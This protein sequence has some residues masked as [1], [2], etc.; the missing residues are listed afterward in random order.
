MNMMTLRLLL[1]GVAAMVL[2]ANVGVAADGASADV[3]ADTGAQ[4][5]TCP[6]TQPADTDPAGPALIP[7]PLSEHAKAFSLPPVKPELLTGL[8]PVRQPLQDANHPGAYV[9]WSR[10]L[11]VATGCGR[12]VRHTPQDIAAAKRAADVVALRNAMALGSGVRIGPTGSVEGLRGGRVKLQGFLQDFEIAHR[13]PI[14]IDGRPWWC[15]E[16]HVPMFGV[17]SLAGTVYDDQLRAV[18]RLPPAPGRLALPAPAPEDLE[19]RDLLIIDARGT[20]AQPAM[21]PVLATED[22]QVILD[23][24]SVP[25]E[26]AIRDGLVVFARTDVAHDELTGVTAEAAKDGAGRRFVLR[27]AG[28]A[29]DQ[30]ATFLLSAPAVETLR[31]DP[32]AAAALR[33]GRVVVLVGYAPQE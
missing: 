4:E 29:K 1:V 8:A 19:R 20:D 21:F 18:R 14:E 5:P 30:P 31:T 23:L 9:D 12:Q 26:R 13:Y 28:T 7:V 32:R 2:C 17:T 27:A 3:P 10:R 6:A 25:R 22:G 15:S 16:V 33:S 24:Q 11:I